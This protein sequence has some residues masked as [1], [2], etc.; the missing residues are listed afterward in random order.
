MYYCIVGLV[1]AWI[2]QEPPTKQT[3]KN[4]LVTGMKMLLEQDTNALVDL[5][6]ISAILKQRAL[7]CVVGQ[8]C[9]G[10]KRLNKRAT[11]TCLQLMGVALIKVH[12]SKGLST[13]LH[14]DCAA[15]QRS[16]RLLF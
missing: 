13:Q 16:A 10:G 7:L 3:P 11:T 14:T 4:R 9:R 6:K 12:F 15:S 5:L 2:N 1:A 8:L